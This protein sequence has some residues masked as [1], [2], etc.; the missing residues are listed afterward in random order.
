M[1]MTKYILNY[2]LIVILLLAMASNALAQKKYYVDEEEVVKAAK[3]EIELSMKEGDFKEY[4]EKSGIKGTYVMD[5]TI[6]NKGQVASVK[7]IEREGE[8]K[9]QNELK[10]F[11][12]EYRFAF[13]MPK[14]KSYKF[15]YQFKF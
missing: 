12:V 2:G 7:T 3:E 6:T 8:V 1:K 4:A 5:I 10:D 15:R 14:N 9:Y 11:V 13:K